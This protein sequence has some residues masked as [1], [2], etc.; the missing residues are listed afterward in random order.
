MD[1][2]GGGDCG[3]RERAF[4][5]EDDVLNL[6]RTEGFAREEGGAKAVVV[7]VVLLEGDA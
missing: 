7:V 1:G 4:G 6:D 2:R 5:G 3:G